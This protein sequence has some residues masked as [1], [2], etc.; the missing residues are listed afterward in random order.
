M[1]M[2]VFA[3]VFAATVASFG[4]WV[5]LVQAHTRLSASSPA[6]QAVLETSP[7][8][9]SLSFSEAVRLTAVTLNSDAAPKTLEVGAPEPAK[10][11][12]VALPALVAGEYVA[13]WRVLSEDTHVM[14][15]E[16]HF[17]VAP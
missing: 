1:K 15:G 2:R 3:N 6:D 12:V 16:I 17:T 5:G 10:D 4:L 8:E 11:F 14:T 7:K 13:Q 9:I